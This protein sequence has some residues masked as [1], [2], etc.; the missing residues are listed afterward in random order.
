MG[1]VRVLGDNEIEVVLTE[2]SQRI[3]NNNGIKICINQGSRNFENWV[4]VELCN[5]LSAA[6]FLIPIERLGV[7]RCLSKE[8]NKSIDVVIEN[9]NGPQVGIEIK[10]IVLGRPGGNVRAG[11][12]KDI[13]TLKALS[14]KKKLLLWVIYERKDGALE[15]WKNYKPQHGKSLK[16]VEVFDKKKDGVNM[17]IYGHVV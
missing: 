11:I 2:L 6:P 4:Q 5:I 15:S 1:Q 9:G 7:E 3:K 17:I 10:I 14:Q 16:P 12:N 8:S 13:T